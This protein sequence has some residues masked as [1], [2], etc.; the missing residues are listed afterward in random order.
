M[1]K[2]REQ[3]IFD[4]M[5]KYCKSKFSTYDFRPMKEVPYP[6]VDFEDTTT[7]HRV[8][9]TDVKGTV[10][11]TIS[12]WGVYTKRKQVSDIASDI[13]NFALGLEET[14]GYHWALNVNSSSIMMMDDNTTVNSLKRA[15][16]ELEFR[17]L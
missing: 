12:V 17:M 13:F 9:K 7:L 2:T 6:F 1:I 11:I 8:N 16:I 5:F 10:S 4:E 3:S 15:V 14:D